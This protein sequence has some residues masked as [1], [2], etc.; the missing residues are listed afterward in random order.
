MARVNLRSSLI[1]EGN[2][3][4]G[5]DLDT[6]YVGDY[7][8]IK[9]AIDDGTTGVNTLSLEAVTVTVQSN[10]DAPDGV[11]VTNSRGR[12]VV[13]NGDE[14][15]KLLTGLDSDII[16]V[17]VTSTDGGVSAYRNNQITLSNGVAIYN[18]TSILLG[19]GGATRSKFLGFVI[20]DGTTI[21]TTFAVKG[22]W[23]FYLDTSSGDLSLVFCTATAASW[24]SV[25]LNDL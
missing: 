19:A 3:A 12:V 7:N 4:D 21:E 14:S 17:L 25:I 1:N 5:T 11:D 20:G 24:K 15:V 16:G 6:F 22:D 9:A 8:K 23:G 10:P 13:R 2:A 18:T